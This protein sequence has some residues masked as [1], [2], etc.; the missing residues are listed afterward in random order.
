MV[1]SFLKKGF[2][3]LHKE[4]LKSHFKWCFD[5]P[6]AKN[7]NIL[8]VPSSCILYNISDAKDAKQPFNVEVCISPNLL[9]MISHK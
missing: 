7:D 4:E 2:L 6:L 1:K 8:Y 3:S 9:R 5:Q